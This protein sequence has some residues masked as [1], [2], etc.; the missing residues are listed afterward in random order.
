[1]DLCLIKDTFTNIQIPVAWNDH[2]VVTRRVQNWI[3]ITISGNP[4]VA[5]ALTQGIK[6][7]RWEIVVVE[8]ENHQSFQAR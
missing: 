5:A 3:S 2:I 1:L 7:L 6:V 8:V 4:E